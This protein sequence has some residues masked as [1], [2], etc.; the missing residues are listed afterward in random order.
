MRGASDASLARKASLSSKGP[1][2]TGASSSLMP[3]GTDPEALAPCSSTGNSRGD[4]LL[5]K[6]TLLSRAG[7]K[8]LRS[9]V[10]QAPKQV[11]QGGGGRSVGVG[12]RAAAV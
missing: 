5:E 2:T 7:S 11:G 9:A 1:S 10:S 3:P 4:E 6:A 8:N 12:G